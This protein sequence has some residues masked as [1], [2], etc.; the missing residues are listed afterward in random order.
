VREALI[1]LFLVQDNILNVSGHGGEHLPSRQLAQELL[2]RRV[3]GSQGVKGLVDSSCE[4]SAAGREDTGR[5][6]GILTAIAMEKKG[7]DR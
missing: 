5:T 1:E 2:R 4:K 3:L 6:V 7:K